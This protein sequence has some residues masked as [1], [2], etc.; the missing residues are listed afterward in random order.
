M[1]VRA[2]EA[3]GKQGRLQSLMLSMHQ[4]LETYVEREREAMDV[5][6]WLRKWQ[7]RRKERKKER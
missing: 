7:T 1:N 2:L 5:F 4:L 6:G 3:I